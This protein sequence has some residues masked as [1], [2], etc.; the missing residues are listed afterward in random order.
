MTS[1]MTSRQ[2]SELDFALERNGWTAQDVKE[3]STGNMLEQLLLVVKGFAEVS[4]VNH[5]INCNKDPLMKRGFKLKK[6]NRNGVLEAKTRGG[7][8]YL[9]NLKVK[10]S[11]FEG[12]VYGNVAT[13]PT[14]YQILKKVKD[15]RVLNAN[16][17]D[18]FLKHRYLFPNNLRGLSE[19]NHASC[20]SFTFWG[21]IYEDV[22]Y[23]PERGECVRILFFHS[24]GNEFGYRYRKLSERWGPRDY[25]LTLS[26]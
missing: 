5:A 14:G 19:E 23:S 7:D 1:I 9:D 25:S 17:L 21:T 16:V 8:L 20:V 24:K 12:Q 26:D 10:A 4:V 6:H 13:M 15:K 22:G 18:D 2:A 11:L 3:V